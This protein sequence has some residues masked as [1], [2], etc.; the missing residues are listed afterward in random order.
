MLRE[1]VSQ[2]KAVSRN[3]MQRSRQGHSA[4]LKCVDATRPQDREMRETTGASAGKG[5]RVEKEG[6]RNDGG[7]DKHPC[8]EH[9]RHTRPASL[10]S[11]SV[12]LSLI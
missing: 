5:R 6:K 7:E 3:G 1:R 8:S 10:L 4:R 11:R 12:L 9:T 2:R